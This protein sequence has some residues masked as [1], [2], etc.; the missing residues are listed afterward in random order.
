[1]KVIDSVLVA[2]VFPGLAIAAT[3]PAK[4]P[5]SARPPTPRLEL[6]LKP[7]ALTGS[8]GYLAVRMTLICPSL[9]AHATLLRM[10]LKIVGI[11]TARYDGDAITAADARGALP[12]VSEEEPP[13]PQWVNR[14][15]NVTRA[16][17]GNVVITYR[18]PPRTVTAAT[19]NGPLFD[20]REEAGGFMGAGV[21]FLALPV[22]EGVYHVRLTWDLSESSPGSR[23]VWSL[24][25]GNVTVEIPAQ[26]LAYSYYAVGPLQSVPTEGAQTFGLY[27]LTDP[28]FD[29]TLLGARI[30]SLYATM[31]QFFGD[32]ASTYRVFMRQNPYAG[33]GGSA[34]AG[35]FMF[36]YNAAEKPSVD[37]LQGLLAHEMTHNWPLLEGEHGD[38]AWYSEGTAEYYSLVLSHRGGQ[39]STDRFVKA[40]NERL[41]AYYTNPYVHLS[42]PEAAKIFWTD[43]IAQTVP[44]GRGF[45]YLVDTD[46]AIRSRSHGARSLDDVVRELYRRKTRGEPYGIGEWISLVGKEIGAGDAQR[47]YDAMV[48]G[49]VLTP[50]AGRFAPCLQIVERPTRAFQ[51]GFARASLNDDRVVRD[52]V[53]SSEAARAGVR[54]GDLIVDVDGLQAAREHDTSTLT[55]KLRRAGTESSVTYLPRGQQVRGYAWTRNPVAPDSSCTF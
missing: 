45:V 52:L 21:G 50:P 10:P 43:P 3:P 30:R 5:A 25:A 41:A 42:N 1:M 17:L 27:W 32:T 51:L 8:S 14:H 4:P 7:H 12:L 38:T 28:P 31:S 2:V 46:D 22:R 47:T 53:P 18:A 16:T 26:T 55:L 15:W 39:L 19:N 24:G 35:S 54:D 49:E 29:A 33:Q 40:I 36:G 11:P 37:D 34:L 20:L 6:V 13:T 44:Y 48:S 23:G 9:G